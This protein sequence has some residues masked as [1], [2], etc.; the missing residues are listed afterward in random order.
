MTTAERTSGFTLVE[1]LVALGLFAVALV[2]IGGLAV[3]ARRLLDAG[4]T[5][6]VALGVARG[7]LDELS[8]TSFEGTWQVLGLD[9]SSAS[10]SV[11][12]RACPWAASW[13][14]TLARSLGRSHARVELATIAPATSTPLASAE[15]IRV[16]VTVHW[17]EGPR[18][19]RVRLVTV[20]T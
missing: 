4:R 12:S 1:N 11:D 3:S 8:G 7:I 14:A 2:A 5:S 9:G 17:I 18:A 6:S 13:Q 19:R 20:R 10:E 15:A 16:V